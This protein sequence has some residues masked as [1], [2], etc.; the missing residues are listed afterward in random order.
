M[1]QTDLM[2]LLLEH[3]INLS[4]NLPTQLNGECEA[5]RPKGSFHMATANRISKI[6]RNSHPKLVN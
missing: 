1:G 6:D 2:T 3:R 4:G 5:V